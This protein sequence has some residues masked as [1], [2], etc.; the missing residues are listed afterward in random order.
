MKHQSE[1]TSRFQPNSLQELTYELLRTMLPQATNKDVF[2]SEAPPKPD[3]LTGEPCVAS[4]AERLFGSVGFN[5][6]RKDISTLIFR[7]SNLAPLF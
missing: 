5:S 6:E 3:L 7:F 1:N 2:V 4:L